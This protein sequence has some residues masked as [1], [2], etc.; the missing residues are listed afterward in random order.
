MTTYN[1]SV[2][3]ALEVDYT[4]SMVRKIAA[5]ISAAVEGDYSTTFGVKAY[6]KIAERTTFL[7]PTVFDFLSL[8]ETVTEAPD[9]TATT[10]EAISTII[11][12]AVAIVMTTLE[13]IP[14]QN[15]TL[16]S[17][18]A[19]QEAIITGVASA[20]TEAPDFTATT[21]ELVDLINIVTEAIAATAALAGASTI[22]AAAAASIAAADS[23]IGALHAPVTESTEVADT[24]VQKITLLMALTETPDTSDTITDTLT[25]VATVAESA[26]TSATLAGGL[27]IS[28]VLTEAMVVSVLFGFAGDEFVGYV[29]NAEG[30]FPASSYTNWPFNS[31]AQL[32]TK[33]YAAQE[34][35]VYEITGSDDA[36]TNISAYIT[37]GFLDFGSSSQ[38]RIRSVQ[39]GYTADDEMRL[40]VRT[41][42]GGTLKEYWYEAAPLTADTPREHVI[43]IGRGLKS[44]YWQFKLINTAGGDFNI[45]VVRLYP[46]LL[47]R[48]Q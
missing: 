44:M 29:V 4:D 21:S 15:P 23:I 8:D 24:L 45:D 14:S 3:F 38:K 36:G 30:A 47:R 13:S 41:E 32:G 46:V 37:T 19:V 48:R 5:A 12:E 7:A 31:Y 28:G 33:T 40:Y 25:V 1:E 43:K 39:L 34:D 11:T 16:T 6:V 22:S 26:V 27:S 2:T 9:F 35:G 42:E 18:L 17:N 10:A 20:L